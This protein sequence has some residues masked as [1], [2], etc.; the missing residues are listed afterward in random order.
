MRR[1]ME[2]EPLVATIRAVQEGPF[3]AALAETFAKAVD[4]RIV[5]R[6]GIIRVTGSAGQM[7]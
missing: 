1:N 2:A 3:A 4:E 5:S 7:V 6:T